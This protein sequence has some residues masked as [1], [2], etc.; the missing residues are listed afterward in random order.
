MNLKKLPFFIIDIILLIMQ[1]LVV[2]FL[3]LSIV[4]IDVFTFLG[5]YILKLRKKLQKRSEDV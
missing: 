1:M 4:M 2:P 3:S 5:E